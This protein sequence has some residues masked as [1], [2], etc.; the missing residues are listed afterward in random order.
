M[1]VVA[2]L[3]VQA[4]EV[5]EFRVG[6]GDR[7][8]DDGQAQGL[9]LRVDLLHQTGVVVHGG[10]HHL[11]AELA[12]VLVDPAVAVVVAAVEA[13]LVP[14]VVAVVVAAGVGQAA[15]GDLLRRRRPQDASPLG[16]VDGGGDVLLRA[17]FPLGLARRHRRLTGDPGAD[18]QPRSV[19][20]LVPGTAWPLGR[21]GA[22]IGL[23]ITEMG[24]DETVVG[25]VHP[26]GPDVHDVGTVQDVDAVDTV[27]TVVPELRMGAARRGRRE[28]RE[29]E[30]KQAG[31]TWAQRMRER[32]RDHHALRTLR[33]TAARDRR[34]LIPGADL[35]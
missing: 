24:T 5:V 20:V 34:T 11:V 4:H 25:D 2:D 31:H 15:A 14:G 1:A 27:G 33:D 18:P 8:L 3:E 35:P 19:E 30:S 23:E 29:H 17:Q 12:E 26:Q 13:V 21:R 9:V 6:P 22:G 32:G 28:A 7:P 16:L 10:D